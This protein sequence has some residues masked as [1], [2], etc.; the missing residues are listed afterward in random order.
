[1]IHIVFITSSI[2]ITVNYDITYMWFRLFNVS[3]QNK[4]LMHATK[5]QIIDRPY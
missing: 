5:K 2:S 4:N 3:P 1:M